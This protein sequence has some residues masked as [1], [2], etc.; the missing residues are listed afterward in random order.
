[1]RTL[2]KCNGSK[3]LS[4]IS[5]LFGI[6]ALLLHMAF[7]TSFI[8]DWKNEWVKLLNAEVD[9]N[10]VKVHVTMVLSLI[11]AF[12]GYFYT[13]TVIFDA[14]GI[15]KV[16]FLAMSCTSQFLFAAL[17][18]INWKNVS[19]WI[20]NHEKIKP[21]MANEN[22]DPISLN[23]LMEDN[24][25]EVIFVWVPFALWLLAIPLQFFGG[26]KEKFDD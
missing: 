14:R 6:T 12:I 13:L 18:S 22:G 10:K 3:L 26:K 7:C 4:K 5:A 17:T 19:N 11:V 23:D 20:K 16:V 8:I 9:F 1:M 25:W 24:R 21:G 2:C 15:F